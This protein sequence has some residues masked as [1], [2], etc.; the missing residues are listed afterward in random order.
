MLYGYD[1]DEIIPCCHTTD[2]NDD[3]Q[4]KWAT[5]RFFLTVLLSFFI[6]F[7]CKN[8]KETKEESGLP[9]KWS[10][11]LPAAVYYGSPALSHDENTLYLGTSTPLSPLPGNH[12]FVALNTTTGQEIWRLPL[13]SNEF[14]SAPVVHT[15]HSLF[16]T[17]ETRDPSNGNI[18]G[19][20]LWHVSQQGEVLWKYE[21]NSSKLRIDVGLSVPA[22]G[23]DGTVYVGG[24]RLYAIHQDGS[25]KWTYASD[26]PEAIRN[27]VSIGNDGTIYFAYHNV[28]L[29]A[30]NPEDGT[31]K[32]ILPLG[33]NDHCFSSPA[34]GSDGTIY[35]ATQPGIIYAVSPN[36]QM[37]W[38][39]NI[40]TVGF[41]GSIR[42]SPSIDHDG[43]IYFGI[44]N[45]Q[46]VSALFAIS[47]EGLIKWIFEPPN[48]PDNVPSNHFDIYSSP[49][50]GADGIL[51]F[52]QEF[53][54]LYALNASD[55]TMASIN[56]VSTAII[57]SSPVID[58]NGVLYINDMSGRVYALQTTGKGLKNSAQWPK[59]RNNNQNTGC[60]NLP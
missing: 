38:S 3:N 27:A 35:V 58:K 22:I 4:V 45:G 48:L 2:N 26:W 51:Y 19:D 59:Y 6:I 57:W 52:G 41:T 53:G 60:V 47:A 40:Q 10:V 23:A 16:F 42:C 25:P 21:I 34:I 37:L 11:Q 36:G 31:I 24:D 15:D 17:V 8:D 49:A 50:I 18:T 1:S 7:G 12:F 33:V 56:N 5:A 13:E 9:V 32:W 30:L 29:T 14:R 28:P 44:T 54:R 43:T 39:F 46:P 20:E 55:G